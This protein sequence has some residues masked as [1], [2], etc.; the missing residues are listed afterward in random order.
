MATKDTHL[1]VPEDLYIWIE[2]LAD[3]QGRS[4]NAQ[5]V[6][7]LKEERARQKAA[8]KM[9]PSPPADDDQI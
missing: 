1:R 7:I 4:I 5:I 3:H 8:K 6:Q 2:E 9:P